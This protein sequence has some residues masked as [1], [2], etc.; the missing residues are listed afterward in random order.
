MQVLL[1]A[2]KFAYAL[3]P[4]E[5]HGIE[6]SLPSERVVPSCSN[7]TAAS[8]MNSGFPARNH[9]FTSEVLYQLSYVG[10]GLI[11]AA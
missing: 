6:E 4:E 5:R 2:R 9:T 1:E 3:L 11:V 10:A 7:A 8:R